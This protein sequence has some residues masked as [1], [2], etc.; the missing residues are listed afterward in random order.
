MFLLQGP[1]GPRGPPGPSGAPVS[2]LTIALNAK[3]RRK[4]ICTIFLL[5]M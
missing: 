2:A 5:T 4:K 3:H 1:M